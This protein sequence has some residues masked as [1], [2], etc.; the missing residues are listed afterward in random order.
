MPWLR[1]KLSASKKYFLNKRVR[2][3]RAQSKLFQLSTTVA[4]LGEPSTGKTTVCRK[5]TQKMY[6]D[7]FERA[8]EYYN[9]DLTLI[10]EGILCKHELSVHDTPGNLRETFP[11]L[12]ESVLRKSDT[13]VLVFSLVSSRGLS[14]IY[15]TLN[16]LKNIKSTSVPTL[17]IANKSD[18]ESKEE[19]DI[20]KRFELYRNA[21]NLNIQICEM[22]IT[23][24][25]DLRHHWIPLLVDIEERHGVF[26]G[27]DPSIVIKWDF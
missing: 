12:Y 3:R 14:A 19:D 16:D 15:R 20:K 2:R 23:Q 10:S 11:L 17:I 21:T 6:P 1:K 8:T 9:L 4:V 18:M 13:F 25:W 26:R 5:L 22:N 24:T 27:H 7:G